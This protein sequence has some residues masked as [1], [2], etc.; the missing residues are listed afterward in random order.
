MSVAIVTGS[1]GGLGAA[2][3]RRLHA[4]GR[5]VASV[6]LAEAGPPEAIRHYRA[7]LTDLG[8]LD[9]L[10]DRI[11]ADAGPVALL[12]NN[13]AYWRPTP[14][15][16]LTADQIRRTL[17]VNVA[18][19]LL[20][21]Q[22]VARRMIAR[23]EGGNIVNIASIAGRRGSSQVD[24][25]ASKAGVINLTMTLARELAAHGIRVNAV[26]P[27]LVDAGMGE[28]LPPH[29]KEAFLAQ[30]PLKRGARP[31]EVANVV[32]FL[33]GEEASYVTGETI[34]VHGGL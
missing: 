3:V 7:D 33:A 31:E 14:F 22:S 19:T 10:V 32:A 8:G 15:L 9:A 34:D 16:E 23:G 20:L 30:T 4:D 21:C 6:D 29:V 1:A 2:I 12:V 28:R 27:A 5:A 17:T 26:A 11:E 13:A 25:G 18:A 24:Y